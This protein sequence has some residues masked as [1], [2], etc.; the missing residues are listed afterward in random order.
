V[1]FH[2]WIE[3]NDRGRDPQAEQSCFADADAVEEGTLGGLCTGSRPIV[4]GAYNSATGVL[5]AYS[6]AGPTVDGRQKPD[7]C[8]PGASDPNG[9]GV[10]AAAARSA[11]P[12]RLNG[13]SMSAPFVSGAIA[14]MFELAA[15][16]KQSLDVE[17]AR[18]MLARTAI[19]LAAGDPA[20]TGPGR[21]D[22]RAALDLL[23][24]RLRAR[25]PR[26]PAGG[27]G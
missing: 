22:V 17:T 15:R 16:Y 6:S 2:A 27:T 18:Q 4:V 21:I 23:Y 11:N 12:A 1:T 8:A 13:T 7:I 26:E 5:E 9:F 19:P 14:L 10:L 25:Q 24:R 3:R 20:G